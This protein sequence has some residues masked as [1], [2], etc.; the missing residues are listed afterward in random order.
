MYA[1]A[2]ARR[3]CVALAAA[4]LFVFQAL[5]GSSALAA[6]GL[7]PG[8]SGATTIICTASG[9]RVV[10]LDIESPAQDVEQHS[11]GLPHC[12]VAGCAMLGGSLLPELFVLAWL[13]PATEHVLPRPA[14]VVDF[15]SALAR[16]PQKSRAPPLPA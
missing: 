9:P 2:H 6:S 7:V 13:V 1:G 4:L 11:G 16:R 8:K 10:I 12:C 15:S 5:I 14:I 3:R